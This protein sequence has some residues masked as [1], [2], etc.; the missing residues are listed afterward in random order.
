MTVQKSNIPL[1]DFL[2]TQSVLKPVGRVQRAVGTVMEVTGLDAQIGDSCEVRNMQGEV[3]INAEVIGIDGEKLILTPH[4]DLRSISTSCRVHLKEKGS[5]LVCSPALLGRIV[6][7]SGIPI[8]GRGPISGGVRRPVYRA[9]PKALDRKLI[10][11]RIETGITAID[12][13]LPLAKGQRIGLFARAGMGKSALLGMISRNSSADVNVIAL[14]GERGREVGEF[15]EENLGAEG[16]KRS[17]LVVAT[18]D[19]SSAERAKAAH[20]ATAIAEWFQH[21]GLDVFLFMDSVTRYARALREIGLGAGE[22]PT[23][24]GFPP[25]VFGALP[26]LFERVGNGPVGSITGAYTVLAEDDDGD[27]PIAEEVKSLLDGHIRLSA[28]LAA[29]AHFPAIDILTS[30]S[31]LAARIQSPAEES[32]AQQV[33][34]ILSKY[35][36]IELLLQLG[37]YK[38]GH[39]TEADRAIHLYQ[40]VMETLRQGRTEKVDQALI[41]EELKN[42]LNV[43]IPEA[44]KQP[45]ETEKKKPRDQTTPEE[46][47]NLLSELNL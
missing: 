26:R 14:I 27:D 43:T 45:V 33:R 4:G 13:I 3:V 40:Q 22:L 23:R 7:P 21:Q 2:A 24:R 42:L 6:G 8:D 36:E 38:E 18:S 28:E 12:Q 41:A 44:P 46:L 35:K 31:R 16:L 47:A 9:A 25:S 10:S 37:E 19:Q 29:K 15:I 17:V 11:N 30:I 34:Q 5:S 20:T 39:D 32:I 1:S